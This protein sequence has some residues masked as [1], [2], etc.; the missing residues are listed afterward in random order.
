ML[1]PSGR[2]SL[3]GVIKSWESA[4]LRFEL[5]VPK[6][7][8]EAGTVTVLS[9]PNGTGK[10][11]LLELCGL[12]TRPDTGRLEIVAPPEARADATALWSRRDTGALA[13]LRAAN[14]GYVLQS[15]HLLPFLTIRRNAELA[16]EIS[17]RTD[18]AH[19]DRLFDALGLAGREGALPETLSPGLRQRAA[20]ARALAHRPR[21]VIAD[22]PTA[23]LD[24]EGGGAVVGLL[25]K[26]AREDGTAV[27]ISTHQ[28]SSV[29]HDPDLIRVRT[30]QLP[31]SVAGVIRAVAEFEVA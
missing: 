7:E 5:S 4:D 15:V 19:L 3:E 26:L 6:L 13:K 12:A 8:I 18:G 29:A 27:V 20:V 30:R 2:I 21:F 28:L 17:Q 25:I 10:T 22:E 16:Q 9:G 1:A 31:E 23:A 24:P 14:F 11:T